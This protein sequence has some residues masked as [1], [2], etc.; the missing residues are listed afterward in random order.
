[1][2]QANI[3]DDEAVE[4][5]R[6]SADAASAYLNGDMR[7]YLTLIRHADD[8][9]FRREASEWRL[10]HRHADPLVHPVRPDLL[11]ALA[12]GEG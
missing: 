8:Y 5:V 1:M 11:A 9:T 4:L 2:T 6:R 3:T 10:A 7:T 12:R